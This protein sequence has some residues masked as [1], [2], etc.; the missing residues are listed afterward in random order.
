MY[1]ENLTVDVFVYLFEIVGLVVGVDEIHVAVDFATCD[2]GELHF[3]VIV[4]IVKQLHDIGRDDGIDVLA[5]YKGNVVGLDAG[6]RDAELPLLIQFVKRI[7]VIDVVWMLGDLLADVVEKIN[8]FFRWRIGHRHFDLLVG[9]HDG[10]GFPTGLQPVIVSTRGGRNLENSGSRAL[11]DAATQINQIAY[12]TTGRCAK[13]PSPLGRPLGACTVGRRLGVVSKASFVVV[14]D[15]KFSL[16]VCLL[17]MAL[18]LNNDFFSKWASICQTAFDEVQ[19]IGQIM[20]RQF[21]VLLG[22]F[23]LSV[24]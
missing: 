18:V 5:K 3:E 7:F 10:N 21:D 6:G 14:Y 11:A 9:N 16:E 22:L 13:K 2:L 15:L 20:S 8:Q 23:K 1:W 17:D 19:A 4:E 24:H 12:Q